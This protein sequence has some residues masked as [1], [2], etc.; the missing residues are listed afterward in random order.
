MFRKA[1]IK[2]RFLSSFAIILATHL[3]GDRPEQFPIAE[4][5]FN[6]FHIMK[7]VNE[8]MNE[9]R[10][11][12]QKEEPEFIRNKYLWLWNE[13]NLKRE[14]KEKLQGLKYRNLKTGRTYRYAG[15]LDDT[16]P[17]C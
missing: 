13:T 14:Q 16:A 15:S 10:K 6:K 7:M 12:E 4:I 9:V 11:A 3:Q 2:N 17:I 1:C 5:T 8:A